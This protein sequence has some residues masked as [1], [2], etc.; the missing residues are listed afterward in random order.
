MEYAIPCGQKSQED[1]EEGI[2]HIETSEQRESIIK[3][4]DIVVIKYSADWCGPCKKLQPFYE[5]LCNNTKHCKFLS[6][7]V[8]DELEGWGCEINSIPVFHIYKNGD[9][10]EAIG[11]DIQQLQKIITEFKSK[12]E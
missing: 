11:G 9:F 2:I 10:S 8:D 1:T 7:D 12:T 3:D 4:N 6:E 5:E